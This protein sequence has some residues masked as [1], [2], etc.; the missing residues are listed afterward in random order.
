MKKIFILL[1]GLSL[2]VS[3]FSGCSA[4]SSNRETV[5]NEQMERT[6]SAKNNYVA[7]LSEKYTPPQN[8]QGTVTDNVKTDFEKELGTALPDDYYDYFNTFG[9]GSFSEYVRI[10]NPFVP[11]GYDEYF[12]ESRENSDI[13]NDI[14]KMRKAYAAGD[15]VA[16]V[17][18][19][20]EIIIEKEYN[21]EFK[22]NVFIPDNKD[23]RSKIVRF[24][25]GFPFDLYKNGNGLVYF[26]HTDDHNFFWNFCDDNYTI[27]MYG[28]SDDFYEYDMSFSEFLYYFLNGD[29]AEINLEEPF[30]FIRND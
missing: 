28:D 6:F 11:S 21:D 24:G 23:I 16:S 25:F 13:Y 5:V 4:S 17:G 9:D 12:E 15:S 22:R 2:L 14:K 10:T 3:A 7:K 20:G 8:P 18:E 19:N 29:L 26:G 27:V 1:L 30:V